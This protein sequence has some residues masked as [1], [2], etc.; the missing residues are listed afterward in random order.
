MLMA[1]LNNQKN[2][3]KRVLFLCL[4]LFTKNLKA[5]STFH[6]T[7]NEQILVAQTLI[8]E[9]KFDEAQK[10]LS[11]QKA[12]SS[13]NLAIPW[14]E[15][16]ALFFKLFITEDEVLLKQQQSHW[17]QL[18]DKAKSMDCGNAWYRFVLSEIYI[19]KALIH[20]KFNEQFYGG[21]DI[22]S[23]FKYLKENKQLYPHFLPD[24]KNYGMLSCVFSS[25][26]SKYQWITRLIGLD[27][28]MVE[29]LKS[30]EL[31]LNTPIIGKEHV[32]IKREAAF[33][34]AMIQHHLNKQTELAW[35]SIEP[36][37]RSYQSNLLEAYMRATIAGY[38]GRNDEMIDIL[39]HKPPYNAQY[40]FYYLDY[41]L[42]LAKLR[43]LDPDADVYFKVFTIKYKGRNYM[44]SAYR[45]LA[46]ISIINND[47]NTAKTYYSLASKKGIDL[48]EEDR[49]AD[50]EAKEAM[51][52]P[53]SLLK[54]RLLFDGKYHDKALLILNAV[55]PA[56]LTNTRY[57]LDFTYRKARVL[58]E[59]KKYQEA[60]VLYKE[61]I[62]KGKTQSYYYAAYSALQL[63]YLY[64]ILKQS[65]QAKT[66][67][68]MAL[69][70]FPDNKEYV[71]SIEQ[72]AKAA[73]KKQTY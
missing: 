57:K 46:W 65:S 49:Y 10:Q 66:Y 11:A 72:K 17:D 25:V 22:Q 69:D 41:M 35:S 51:I 6:F 32:V 4:L 64:D 62:Q 28:N 7:M 12:I 44:K 1:L 43:R 60:I 18:L 68:N 50:K 67:Y 52:W 73:L 71:S 24:N 5:I 36:Y 37:T 47:I 42:G 58:H 14:L 63:G 29:G 3:L 2:T 19:H 59:T 21:L 16:S 23:A 27:G 31:Y 38:S 34:Y 33:I 48:I 20:L 56:Q 15:E 54:A 8:S 53:A 45:Y 9:L 61:V 70:D 40:A 26:P 30:I 39:K 55:D 13:N